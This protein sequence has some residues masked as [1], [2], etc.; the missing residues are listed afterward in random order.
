M[1]HQS[2]PLVWTETYTDAVIVDDCDIVELAVY[3]VQVITRAI[4]VHGEP[5]LAQ[6]V[7]NEWDLVID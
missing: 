6:F 5:Y 1:F 3:V 2:Q 7:E 4:V